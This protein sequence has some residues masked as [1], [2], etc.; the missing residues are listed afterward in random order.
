VLSHLGA[1]LTGLSVLAALVVPAAARSESG[2][3]WTVYHGDGL[4][5][6]V[7]GGVASVDTSRRSWTSPQ[8]DGQLYGEPLVFAS[9]VFV[10]TETDVVYALSSATGVVLWSRRLSSPVPSSDLPCGN[11][12]PDVGITGTPVIDPYRREIYVVADEL[13]GGS[14]RHFLVGLDTASGAVE[15]SVPVDPP[16]SDPASL[17]QR[18]GLA[19]DGRSVVF[20]MGGNYGDCGTYRGRVV[21]VAEAGGSPRYF[22]V[23]DGTGQSQGAVWMG[24]AAPVVDRSG[25]IWVTAGN[26]SVT[27]AAQRYDYSDSVLELSS[28]LDL[29]QY[30][31]PTD[32]RHDNAEDLDMSTA[33]AL[34]AD[35]Q[36]VA[37]G[38]AGIAYVLDGIHLGGIGGQSAQLAAA[39]TDDIDGGAVTSGST[40]YLPCLAGPVA[41]AVSA[42]PP[43]AR[44][45]WRSAVGGG[46][47]VLADG[48]VWTISSNGLLYGLSPVDGAVRQAVSVGSVANHFPTPAAGGGH[49]LVATANRVVAFE[50]APTGSSASPGGSTTS[51]GAPPTT[52]ANAATGT[53]AATGPS[54]SHHSTAVPL[55]PAVIALAAVSGL[56]AII[57]T[58]RRR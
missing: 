45:I 28:S 7:A 46:P 33:P 49:L 40:V 36:V 6:G 10:A 17:L 16:G 53:R 22:T 35:G 57:F 39:C 31:A 37:A 20:G 2:E 29:L 54:Q 56:V 4:G 34:L 30:F 27:S 25:R 19:L 51:S 9:T 21:S 24:G 26:G 43:G 47:P 41:V 12:K 52:P 13:V 38:K 58:R 44:V 5:D 15:L 8:L 50:A 3:A 55:A 48:L 11:I 42:S 18:T 23:D 1:A 32:W 14:P